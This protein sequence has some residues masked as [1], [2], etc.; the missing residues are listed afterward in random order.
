MSIHQNNANTKPSNSFGGPYRFVER[1]NGNHARVEEGD[2]F[3]HSHTLQHAHLVNSH[4][5]V[6]VLA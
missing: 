2:T 6:D 4:V 5:A 1:V 3:A